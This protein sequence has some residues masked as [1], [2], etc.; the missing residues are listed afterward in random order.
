L[1]AGQLYIQGKDDVI[2]R[3]ALPHEVD[4]LLFQAHDGIAG[5]HFAFETTTQKVLQAGLWWP[6]LFKDAHQYVLRCDVCQRANRP[7][8]QDHMPLHPVLP[9]LPFEK[10]GL[11]YVGPI[12]PAARGSQARY[13]KVATDYMTKWA[14]ARA[15]RK[16]DAR[17][18]TKFIYEHIITRFGCPIEMV[19][20]RGTHFINEV[21]TELLTKFMVIH[22]KSTPYYPRRNGQAES[23]NKIL[24]GILTKICEVKRTDW[25][26]KLHFALWAYRTAYKTS[27]GQT[28]FQLVYG[29]EAVMPAEFVVPNLRIVVEERL[30]GVESHA[31]RLESLEKL[32]EARQLAIHAMVV[33]KRR[34][35]AWYDKT[36]RQKELHDGDLALLYN[37]KK[38][39]G[40]LKLT[41]NGPYVVHHINENGAV[42]LKTLE[43]ELFPRYING[44]RLKR[45][46]IPNP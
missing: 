9:Q 7:T 8:N 28:P 11:D 17:S 32:T 37:S 22:R 39:K 36:L 6:T 12:K 15:V 19:T 26:T 31:K 1:I 27:V 25:E 33:E 44:S 34:R 13:I 21:I 30:G 38:H 14:E 42:M 23:T 24:S 29:L 5:G 4:D 41:E 43:G 16:A 45:F 35:K 18:T 40:K 46:Y 2:R 3:C 20:D 10:W